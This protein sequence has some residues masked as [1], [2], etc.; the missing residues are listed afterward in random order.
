MAATVRGEGIAWEWGTVF[1][2]G[3]GCWAT[4]IF[5]QAALVVPAVAST[6]LDAAD[7]PAVKAQG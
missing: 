6:I 1:D 5:V 3:M 4:W 2:W 7:A